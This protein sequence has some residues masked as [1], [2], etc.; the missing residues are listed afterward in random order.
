MAALDPTVG[1]GV[2]DVLLAN[3]SS[4]T[5]NLSLGAVTYT[6]PYSVNFQGTRGLAG[7]G[8]TNITGTSSTTLAGKVATGSASVTNVPTKANDGA[9]SI[10]T[11]SAASSP[12]NGIEIKDGNGT[13]KRVLFGPTSDLSKAFG[14]GDILALPIGNLSLTIT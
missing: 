9:I 8:G 6:A 1:N 2:N 7:T 11:S 12:W 13:P 3:A 4:G 14:S 10:T 5:T